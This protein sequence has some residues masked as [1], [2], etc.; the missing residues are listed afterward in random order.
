MQER[1]GG[2]RVKFI[3]WR[4]RI[5]GS[6]A[7]Q[8]QAAAN[9]LLR[10]IARKRAGALFDLVAGFTYTQTLLAT[11]EAGWVERLA[12]GPVATVVLAAQADLGEEAATRLLRAAAAIGIAQE[13]QD[14]W[15]MLG[16]HGAALHGNEGALAM[17]RHH[18]LLYADLADPLALLRAD[19]VNSTELSRFWGYAGQAEGAGEANAA[20][21]SH[22]M[23]SSQAAVSHE[24]LSA[25]DL[26]RHA[27]LLDVGGGRGTFLASVA[28][29]HP[30]L[31]L[32]LF[33]LPEVVAGGL[34]VANVETHP[35]SFF[36]DELPRGYDCISLVRILHDH[37][38]AAALKILTNI[39]RA[40][41]PGKVVL[42]GEPMAQTRGA[43][44]MGDAYFGLYLWAMGQGRP[45]TAAEIRTMLAE[46]G[47]S[48]SRQV[49][50]RQ[51]IIASLI[52]ACA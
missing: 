20:A 15:W 22:L 48:E 39:R 12:D 24:I 50:T 42:I 8:H 16:R 14:G 23:S 17:I 47:F 6:R 28:R 4:N 34:G 13:V 45:R 29:A 41:V 44:A 10:P 9:P 2:W 7:F 1:P 5:L 21:Y 19:R 33:D 49:P 27:S 31:R 46:A 43:E 36:E 11:V 32:G 52:V 30:R 25:Y 35:G 51:P 18:R 40:L 26:S 37:D 38:D 3:G